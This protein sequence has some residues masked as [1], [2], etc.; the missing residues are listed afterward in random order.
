MNHPLANGKSSRLT[1]WLIVREGGATSQ[2]KLAA[3]GIEAGDERTRFQAFA[4]ELES[5]SGTVCL[6]TFTKTP[7][8]LSNVFLT[9]DL[10]LVRV[11][12]PE[13]VESFNWTTEPEDRS[14][15]AFRNMHKA[16]L[17]RIKDRN[18]AA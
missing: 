15:V 4:E 3:R 16:R 1:G 9:F 8:N 13:G 7:I 17:K 5:W 14:G 10:R 18:D 12:S 2:A 6:L 11:C